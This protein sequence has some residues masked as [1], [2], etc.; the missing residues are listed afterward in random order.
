MTDCI[1]CKI[2]KKEIPAKIVFEDEDIIAF[3]DANP[4]APIH[5]LIIPKKHI[6]SVVEIKQEDT[7]LMGRLTM[8]AKK[9]ADDLEISE[10]GYKLLMRVGREGGQEVNHVHLHLLGGAKLTEN[11]CPADN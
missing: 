5:V 1:F 4:I 2:I 6:V 10:K 7:M 11:I 9:I 8:V 3:N